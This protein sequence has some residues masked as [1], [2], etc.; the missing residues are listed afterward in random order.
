MNGRIL[1]WLALAAL[2][3]TGV[4]LWWVSRPAPPMAPKA[5]IFEAV[6][7]AA[8]AGWAADDHAAALAAFR[9]SCAAW[10]K[11]KADRRSGAGGLDITIGDW[12][13]ACAAAAPVDGAPGMPAQAFFETWFAAY[14]VTRNDGDRGLFTGYYEPL[15]RGSRVKGGPTPGMSSQAC[16][17]RAYALRATWPSR[18][19]GC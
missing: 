18:S 13:D 1:P 6:P 11:R 10:A 2:V 16:L 4:L 15:L 5:L 7:Y 8:L 9:L 17:R 14:A 3:L 12:G 19:T